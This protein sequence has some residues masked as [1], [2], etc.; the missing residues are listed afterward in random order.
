M[1]SILGRAARLPVHSPADGDPLLGGHIYVAPPDHHLE[2]ELGRVRL[3]QA[4]R[5]NGHRPA[6]DATMRSAALAYDGAVV[7]FVLTGSRDDGTAGLLVIKEHGGAAVRAGSRRGAV[8]RECRAARSTMWTWM[9]CCRSRRWRTGWPTTRPRR[10]PH[11]APAGRVEGRRRARRPA[12]LPQAHARVRLHRLQALQP[13]CAASE[14]DAARSGI[15]AYAEYLDYLEVHPD[16]FTALFNTILINVTGVLPRPG[17]LGATCA[18][19]IVPAHRS[20][21]RPPDEP[22]R[23]WSAGCASGEEAYTLAMLLAEALGRAAVPR[24]GEDLRHRRRRGG[25]GPGPPRPPTRPRTSR[26][27][28][29]AAARALLRARRASATCSARTCAAR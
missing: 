4:P 3:T 7:G 9:P 8:S 29:R 1:P 27:C 15:D 13:R 28:R 21:P 6:I 22:I 26:T 24:A 25:A 10:G 23:V 14:A 18:T 2:L 11:D 17:S 16:E 5:E 12:R 20:R 19:E